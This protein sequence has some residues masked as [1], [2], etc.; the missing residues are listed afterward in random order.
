MKSCSFSTELL[1]HTLHILLSNC[2]PCH[3][4]V[5]ICR[6]NMPHLSWAKYDLLALL[7][8]DIT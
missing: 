8:N 7:I 2:V 4:P 3:M 1:L 6:S 5:Y